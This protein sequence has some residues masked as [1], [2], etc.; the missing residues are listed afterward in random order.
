M[1]LVGFWSTPRTVIALVILAAGVVTTVALAVRIK[2][3]AVQE[4]DVHATR[5]C[6]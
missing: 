1:G 3:G 4:T 2:N 6:G 5:A